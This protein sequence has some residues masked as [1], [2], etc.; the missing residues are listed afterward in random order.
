MA[1]ASSVYWYG[2]RHSSSTSVYL[3]YSPSSRCRGDRRGIPVGF[4]P[5][6]PLLGSWLPLLPFPSHSEQPTSFAYRKWALTLAHPC[7][8]TYWYPPRP[9]QASTFP[10]ETTP[11]QES[12]WMKTF[13]SPIRVILCKSVSDRSDL[14]QDGCVCLSCRS[15]PG[16]GQRTWS[17]S[18]CLQEECVY[19]WIN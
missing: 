16:R 3:C 19:Q 1:A 15:S 18:T 12:K 14:L 4:L 8:L 7:M 11:N 17:V 5:C 6:F 2:R 9:Q 13:I 10:S